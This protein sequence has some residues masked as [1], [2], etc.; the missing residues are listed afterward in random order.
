[1]PDGVRLRGFLAYRSHG[2][3]TLR[4]GRCV[5]HGFASLVAYAVQAMRHDG[6]HEGRLAHFAPMQ[7]LISRRFPAGGAVAGQAFK[8]PLLTGSPPTIT[9][10]ARPCSPHGASRFFPRVASSGILKGFESALPFPSAFPVTR[11]GKSSFLF[12]P[13]PECSRRHPQALRIKK[14]RSKIEA[15]FSQS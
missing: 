7:P 14:G 9:R 6:G 3:I 10:P 15:A 5:V 12:L 1:M 2:K 11:K 8:H 4:L 13:R